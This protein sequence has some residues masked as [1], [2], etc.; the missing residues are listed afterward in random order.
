M[1]WAQLAVSV[2]TIAATFFGVAYLLRANKNLLV[3]NANKTHAETTGVNLDNQAK[4]IDMLTKRIDALDA[5][6][7]VQRDERV[8]ERNHLEALLAVHRARIDA[9]EA[10]IRLNTEHD[11][12]HIT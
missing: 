6:L 3:A 2:L 11:P 8:K 9:L 10:F 4:Q 7:R 1:M 5:E 12:A